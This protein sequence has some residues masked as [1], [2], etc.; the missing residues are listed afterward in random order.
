MKGLY[1]VLSIL[2]AC[3][4]IGGIIFLIYSPDFLNP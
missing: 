4:L 2:A 3:F 1:I